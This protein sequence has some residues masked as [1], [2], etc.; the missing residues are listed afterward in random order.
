MARPINIPKEV[1]TYAD[2]III[3]QSAGSDLVKAISISMALKTDLGVDKISEVLN[4]N[5]RTFFKYRDEFIARVKTPD[6]A[7]KQT[8]GGR[9]NFLMTEKEEKKFLSKFI[10]DAKKGY[11]VSAVPIHEALIKKLGHDVPY[12]TTTRMLE[13]NN[14]RAVKPDTRHP[15]SDQQ[16]QEAFKKNSRHL[17]QPPKK[18]TLKTKKCC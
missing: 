16:A 13:R 6:E 10:E 17:W 8:W 9:R 1:L 2:N 5:R 14:W 18:E 15:K 11:L 3:Q 12:S 4:I 7:N